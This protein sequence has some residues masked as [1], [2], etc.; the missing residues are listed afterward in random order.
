MTH[1][2][3]TLDIVTILAIMFQP[4]FVHNN[5]YF[6]LKLWG[7]VKNMIKDLNKLFKRRESGGFLTSRIEISWRGEN[8][9]FAPPADFY[10][11]HLG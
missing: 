10:S 3:D 9:T 7:I 6:S 2:C 4:F 11:T 5:K 8:S 1:I